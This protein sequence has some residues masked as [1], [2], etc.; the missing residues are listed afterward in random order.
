MLALSHRASVDTLAEALWREGAAGQRGRHHPHAGVPAAA[1]LEDPGGA[2]TIRSEGGGYL[3]EMEPGPTRREPVP[4][5]RRHRSDGSRRWG[6]GARPPTVCAGPCRSGGVRARRSRRPRF[7]P[8][9]R[10]PARRRPA[11][12]R[13]KIWPRRSWRSGGP[14]E[15]AGRGRAVDGRASLP[16]APAGAADAGPLPPRP[17]GRG[18]GRLPGA[19]QDAR[20]RARARPRRRPSRR[21]SARSSCRPRARR[22]GRSPEALVVRPPWRRRT[23][24]AGADRARWPFSSPTSRPAPAAGRATAGHGRRP[25]P[26]RRVLNGAVETH[27]GQVF[28]HTGDGIGAAFPTAAAAL[29]AAVAGQH[30]L[31]GRAGRGQRRSR[32]AWPSTPDRRGPGGHVPR[33]DL[34]RTARLLDEARGGEIRVLAGSSRP[35][36]RRPAFRRRTGRHSENASWRGSLARRPLAGLSIRIWYQ[37]PPEPVPGPGRCPGPDLARGPGSGA[38]R[39]LRRR[40]PEPTADHHGAG[41]RGEDPAR[42][43]S[44]RH[45]GER[46]SR[47]APAW[48]SS[49]ISGPALIAHEILAA[50]GG[51]GGAREREPTSAGSPLRGAGRPPSPARARQLRA[52]AR[53]ACP[54]GRRPAPAH[55]GRQSCWPPA[56]RCSPFPGES[57]WR[58]PGLSLP[59]ADPDPGE[60]LEA[61]TRS[62]LFVVRARAVQPGFG[63]HSGQRA[64]VARI[65][66]RL[67]GIPLALELAAARVRVLC[68]SQLADRLDRR[69]RL[70]VGGPRSVATRH[71]TLRAAM[72][73]SF[74]LLPEP[75]RQ[76]LRC[77]SMFPQSFD[78]DAATAMA[79]DDRRYPR[80]ARRIASLIDKSLLVAEGRPTRRATGCSTPSASTAPSGSRGGRGSRDPPPAPPSLRRPRRRRVAGGVNLVGDPWLTTVAQDRENY[81]AALEDAVADRGWR[82]SRCSSSGSTTPGTGTVRCRRSLDTIDPD[83]WPARTPR[84]T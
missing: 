2:I 72:D 9:G 76:L 58:A 62:A 36:S 16:G 24:G 47:T 22:P 53:R 66:R 13:P 50:L 61:P 75:E 8:H 57:A 77:L 5:P 51:R 31:A 17:S 44:W 55:R 18:P 71:Q 4:R 79:G 40:W 6:I 60:E 11:G 19:A 68:V 43:R 23:A 25:R 41:R 48:W 32:C 63:T 30:A 39:A 1:D 64:A 3:I 70:L 20:R 81:H 78:L 34:N 49:P 33:S 52:G 80:R 46:S 15:G 82:R 27:G 35:G 45:D 83:A 84:S 10:D 56:A 14:V 42:L 65:C 28:T 74:E 69:F 54:D 73:W 37:L 12:R 26:P 38:G 29:A 59:P 7:R 21:W 67:E